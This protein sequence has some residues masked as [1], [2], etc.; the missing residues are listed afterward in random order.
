ME[1]WYN[2]FKPI[3]N[4]GMT[5]MARHPHTEAYQH[6]TES[7]TNNPPAGLAPDGDIPTMPKNTYAYNPHLHPVLRFHTEG[8]H[9]P[10][11][12]NIA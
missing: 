4:L 6:D 7:R 9:A 1:L 8:E 5:P 3:L 11:P 10:P 12:L 2:V